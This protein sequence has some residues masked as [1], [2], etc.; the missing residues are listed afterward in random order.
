MKISKKDKLYLF[1]KKLKKTKK[2]S[3]KLLTNSL[4]SVIISNVVE[5]RWCSSVGRAADL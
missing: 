1:R 3:K 4:S 5:I 2:N